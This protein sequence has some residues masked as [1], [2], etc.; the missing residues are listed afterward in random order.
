M[1]VL[2]EWSGAYNRKNCNHLCL[3]APGCCHI[4]FT[5]LLTDLLLQFFMF[6][7]PSY[8][9]S[10][11]SSLWAQHAWLF[12]S[13]ATAPPPVPSIVC[14][15]VQLRKNLP[16]LMMRG[17]PRFLLHWLALVGREVNRYK[18][19]LPSFFLPVNCAKSLWR[20]RHVFL[21]NTWKTHTHLHSFLGTHLGLG[22]SPRALDRL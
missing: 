14:F 15:R 12:L 16:A 5:K 21:I 7:F 19:L 1:S 3:T 22:H 18:S 17:K 13:A 9:L 4:T 20:S 2:G 10:V 8:L 11:L 6:A